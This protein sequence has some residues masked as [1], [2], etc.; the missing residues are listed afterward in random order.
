[1]DC[2]GKIGIEIDLYYLV[3]EGLFND[4][5]P[6]LEAGF[7]EYELGFLG[8]EDMKAISDIPHRGF[9]EDQLLLRLKEGKMCFGVKYGGTIA[10]FTWCNLDECHYKGYSFPLENDQAYLFDAYTMDSFRG[11]G[12]APYIRYQS[13]KELEKIGRK[14]LYSISERFNL[15]SIKFKEKLNARLVGEGVCVLLLK[16]WFFRS[17]FR[18]FQHRNPK[19]R[20]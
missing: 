20:I 6:D 16:K 12:I 18:R 19:S 7:D 10:A 11:K 17:R 14:T 13:Y 1:M 3:A 15:S 2:L 8:P 5:I 9:S 4:T